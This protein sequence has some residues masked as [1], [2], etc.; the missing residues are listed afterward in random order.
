MFVHVTYE[1]QVDLDAI[2][3]PVMR[4]ATITQVQNF[5]QTPSRIEKKPFPNAQVPCAL[6]DKY[7]DFNALS[8]LAHSTP[9]FCVVGAPHRVYVEVKQWTT[10][11]V[12]MSGQ[13][14]S[15]VG[16]IGHSRGNIVAVGRTCT[17]IR[18]AMTYF[19]YGG[20]NNGVS[21]HVGAVSVRLGSANSVIS[22]HDDMHS[23]PICVAKASLNGRWLVTG[24]EDS[25]VRVWRAPSTFD[26]NARLQLKAVFCGHENGKITCID[27][28]TVSG[29]VVTGGSDGCVLMWDLRSCTFLRQLKHGYEERRSISLSATCVTSV[30]INKSNGNVLALVRNKLFM[31]DVNGF[32]IATYSQEDW[33]DRGSPTCAIATG[34]PEWMENGVAAITGHK[35]GD[36][37]LWSVNYGRS[38][39]LMRHL[40]QKKVHTCPITALAVCGDNNDILLMGDASGKVSEARTLKLESLAAKELAVIVKELEAEKQEKEERRKWKQITSE[41]EE[42]TE[43]SVDQDMKMI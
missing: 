25:T 32:L 12:G 27:V 13:D 3:D 18:P 11:R 41:V 17:L 24:C 42:S 31:F 43:S 26:H 22:A 29:I 5:G 8:V 10:C 39:F 34:C 6:K 7:I 33:N 2:D 4:E 23:A 40:V 38:A 19:R 37:R 36:V 16:D 1:G 35:N 20:P 15:A 28:D 30:S 9:P 14:D 21:V